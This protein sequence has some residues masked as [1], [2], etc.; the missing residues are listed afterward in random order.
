LLGAAALAVRKP[1]RAIW[2]SALSGLALLG[3]LAVWRVPLLVPV[4][5]AASWG[6]LA[7]ARPASAALRIWAGTTATALVVACA[8]FPYL[9]AQDHVVSPATLVVIATAA[10]LQVPAISRSTSRAAT[11]AVAI[12]LAVAT[13]AALGTWLVPHGDYQSLA[14]LLRFRLLGLLGLGGAADPMT[15]VL[16]DVKELRPMDVPELLGPSGFSWLGLWL[17]AAPV[18]LWSR[19]RRSLRD[20]ASRSG[21]ALVVVLVTTAGLVPLSL[22]AIRYR[23]LLVPQI[24]VLSGLCVSRLINERSEARPVPGSPPTGSTGGATRPAPE[25]GPRSQPARR[26]AERRR[27]FLGGTNVARGPV[28]RLALVALV[29]CFAMLLRDAWDATVRSGTP[30]DPGMAASVAYLKAQ[31]E[32]G[33]V[34]STWD[35]GY[36]LQCY[37]GCATITD[38]L[39]E[40]EV[41]QQHILAAARGYV[42]ATPESLAVLCERFGARYVVVPPNGQFY[43]EALAA[44]DPLAPRIAARLPLPPKARD[45]LLLRMMLTG[46]SEPPFEPVFERDQYRVYRRSPRPPARR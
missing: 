10:I 4:L 12:L 34:L 7:V 25:P 11:R 37:A 24:A 20:W 15:A 39:L 8:S 23:I 38:G 28:E 2:L 18:A 5:E 46:T 1:S 33:P 26:R 14:R 27:P 44:G 42:A 35:R 43:G 45:R 17:V 16:L 13:A 21:D 36:E 32:H 31:G 19:S 22:L 30:L 40:S 41:N 29:P 9:R 3:A 6:V